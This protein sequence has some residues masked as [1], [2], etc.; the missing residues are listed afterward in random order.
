M[1]EE[2]TDRKTAEEKL[3]KSEEKYKKLSNELET[4]LDIIP[5][6]IFIKDKD[7]IYTRVNQVF[8]DYLQLDKEEILGKSTLDFFPQELAT[9][10]I[11]I[12]FS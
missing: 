6:M 9:K 8:A 10:L 2:I 3:Q 11:F 4:M 7:D 5:G 12:D 1:F